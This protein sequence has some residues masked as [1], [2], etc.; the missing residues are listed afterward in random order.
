MIEETPRK[1]YSRD[2]VKDENLPLIDVRTVPG[3]YTEPSD[4]HIES[5]TVARIE[6]KVITLKLKFRD[7]ILVSQQAESK[8]HLSVTVN[9][10]SVGISQD[11]LAL[12][13]STMLQVELPRMLAQG[14]A[15]AIA[16]AGQAT[17]AIATAVMG[18]NFV[19][20][21]ILAASLSQLWS[22]L[23]G[24][25]LAVHLPL[26]NLLFPANAN[27]FI[28]FVID[29]AT[30]DLVPPELILMIFS[31]PEDT[32]PFSMGFDTTGYSSMYPV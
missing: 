21:L 8:D 23:N 10:A 30:F 18:G 15:E 17:E 11:G 29:L 3:L 4:L 7:P 14:E 31:F 32:E 12:Y 24:L 28:E 2:T 13:D 22:M 1:L 16:S 9:L 19:I 5:W 27:M 20:N 6:P 25:Q 26:F